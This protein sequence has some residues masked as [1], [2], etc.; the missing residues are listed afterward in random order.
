[1]YSNYLHGIREITSDVI[2]EKIVN[3]DYCLD[4]KIGDELKR[5]T[6]ISL[7]IRNVPKVLKARFLFGL[8]R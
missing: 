7:T 6:R 5:G 2:D 3:L 1:M 8:K 4:R